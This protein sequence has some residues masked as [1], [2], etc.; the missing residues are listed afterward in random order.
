MSGERA[1]IVAAGMLI[2]AVL[3]VLAA[4][5]CDSAAGEARNAP[6]EETAPEP[7]GGAMVDL[8][9][10]QLAPPVAT[11]LADVIVIGTVTEDSWTV[12]GLEPTAEGLQRAYDK[13]YTEADVATA[14]ANESDM[15]YTH[16]EVQVEGTLKGQRP[17]DSIEVAVLGGEH[18]GRSVR[19]SN[20]VELESGKRYVIFLTHDITEA[21]SP[22][23]AFEIDGATATADG[24]VYIGSLPVEDLLAQIEAHKDDSNPYRPHSE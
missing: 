15:V 18:E 22:F 9:F 11:G 24:G 7:D 5:G 17:G 14:I 12:L 8:D 20:E 23:C 19:V 2:A 3:F 10:P 6:A 13:G 4:G 16:H 1:S 21:Y